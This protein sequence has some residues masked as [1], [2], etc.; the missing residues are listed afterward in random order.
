MPLK[1]RNGK[2]FLEEVAFNLALE[3]SGVFEKLE[4]RLKGI[5]ESL[6]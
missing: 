5:P 6:E 4:M 1:V 2:G 3:E